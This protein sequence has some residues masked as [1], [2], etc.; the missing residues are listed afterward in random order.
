MEYPTPHISRGHT[1]IAPYA[2]KPPLGGDWC[3]SASAHSDLNLARKTNANLLI[4][5]TKRVA[6][7][8]SSLVRELK[9]VVTIHCHD[10]RLVLPPASSRARTAI[11][12][13]VDALTCQQ[14]R[15]LL[16]WL[17]D[18]SGNRMQVIS[19]ASAPLL[20]L[21]ESGTFHDALYYRL[22][23]VYIDLSE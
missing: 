20:P 14:Q 23:T 4:V 1:K 9:P 13:D 12:R 11:V 15:R 16:A 7:L 17:R 10:G 19:T 6:N 5:G 18:S 8:L 3:L 21:V 22:N 2:S